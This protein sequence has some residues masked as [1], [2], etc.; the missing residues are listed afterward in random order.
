[1]NGLAIFGS[2]PWGDQ[3]T[4]TEDGIPIRFTTRD[5]TAYAI[6]LGTP[7]GRTIVL[8]GLRLQPY[9]GLR[10]L[11][12]VGYTAWFQ[13]GKDLH[14]RLTEPLRESPAHVISITQPRLPRG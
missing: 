13:R 4:E 11:G 6:L 8:P 3:E 1:L 14:V 10:V 12:S 9:A 7:A 2:R 5:M